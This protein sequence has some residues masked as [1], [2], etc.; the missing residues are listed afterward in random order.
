[1]PKIYEVLAEKYTIHSKGKNQVRGEVPVAHAPRQV[2]QM[3]SID[4]G[5]VF[6][7]TAIDIWSREVDILLR[8]TL[9]AADGEA[10]LHF[11]RRRR[12]NRL[13][14]V[15]PTDGS[16]EFEAQFA[17]EVWRYCQQHRIARPYK[18]NEQSYIE[19]FNRMVR[20]ECL[21]WNKYQADDIKRLTMR[22]E[23]FLERYHYHRAHLAFEPMR[24]PLDRP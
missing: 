22:V 8:P 21:G 18:K 19:S 6:A 11:C 24:P 17:L 5:G 1:M 10:F 12:F 13:V 15:L 2:I 23:A 7:F 16:S 20:K 3:D 9:T 14:R 4:F